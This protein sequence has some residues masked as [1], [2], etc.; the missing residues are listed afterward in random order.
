M[1]WQLPQKPGMTVRD[2]WSLL[3]EGI[4]SDIS[5]SSQLTLEHILH[6]GN[7]SERI[8]RACAHDFS[9]EKVT[10]IYQKLGECLLQNEQ[11]KSL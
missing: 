10:C 7:L 9:K 3:I 6:H 11:F 2:V 1:Q 5:Q 8:L 4:S